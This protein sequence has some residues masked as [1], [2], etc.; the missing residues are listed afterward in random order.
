MGTEIIII[1]VGDGDEQKEF[2]VHK[3]L[4]IKHSEY[5]QTMFRTDNWEEAKRGEVELE[6]DDPEAFELFHQF[7]YTGCVFSQKQGDTARAVDEVNRTE[8]AGAAAGSADQ[9]DRDSEM[10]RLCRAWELGQKLMSTSF[11]DAITDTMRSKVRAGEIPMHAN[12]WIYPR[13]PENAAMRRLL[14]DI[15]V[16]YVKSSV[17]WFSETGSSTI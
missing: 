3:N 10:G 17:K 16:W 15:A 13:S 6:T 2:V 14:V 7:V 1:H 4:L 5:F 9:S 8:E 12:A 11:K